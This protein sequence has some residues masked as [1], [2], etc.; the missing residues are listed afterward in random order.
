MIGEEGGSKA[1]REWL[2]AGLVSLG[3]MMAMEE[4]ME[5]GERNLVVTEVLVCGFLLRL[6]KIV[7]VRDD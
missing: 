4:E 2:G 1:V 7:Y 5:V 3:G 6:S